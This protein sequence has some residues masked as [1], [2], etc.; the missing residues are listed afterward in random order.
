MHADAEIIEKLNEVLTA[1]LTAI[2]QYFLHGKMQSNWGYKKL[3]EHS[4]EESVDEM[5]HADQITDRILY[6]DGVPN[7]QRLSPLRIGEN[8][9][10]QFEADLAL[11]VEAVARLNEAVELAASS[12]DNGTRHLFEDILVHEEEHVDW[13]ET[14]LE[15]IRQIGLENYLSQQ[16]DS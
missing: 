3:G 2:N 16:L 7:Y 5:R 14:Q 15:T 8:V 1:E 10:E 6:F 13:I 12:G 11:E 9:V 4:R